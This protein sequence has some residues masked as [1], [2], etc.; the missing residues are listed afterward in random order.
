MTCRE[1][2]ELLNDFV[3]GELPQDHCQ[4]IRE[5]LGLCP[6]CVEYVASYELTIQLTRQ[7]PCDPLPQP[8][9]QR[10]REL[11]GPSSAG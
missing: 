11:L 8:L 7:L 4:R 1:L 3:A 9:E 6:P 5:H 2:V 10:L